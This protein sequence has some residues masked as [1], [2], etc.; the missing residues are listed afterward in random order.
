MIVGEDS[1]GPCIL[2]RADMDALPVAETAVVEYEGPHLFV[3]SMP[4]LTLENDVAS[5]HVCK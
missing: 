4:A 2:L 5:I 3:N 1:E